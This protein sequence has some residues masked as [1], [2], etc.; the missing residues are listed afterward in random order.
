MF[1]WLGGLVD[2]NEK[3]IKRLQPT[4]D[5]INELE[6]EFERLNDAELCAKTDDFKARLNAGTSLDEL[7]PEGLIMATNGLRAG[8]SLGQV[9]EIL[10]R[11]APKPLNQEFGLVV[12]EQRLGKEFDEALR[13]LVTRMPTEVDRPINVSRFMENPDMLMNRKADRMD[14]GM[15]RATITVER[16]S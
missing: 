8:M 13:G 16:M 5:R 6:P 15:D 7:L 1:K 14:M 11:E 3:E 9:L 4:V 10:S 2:S 12:K